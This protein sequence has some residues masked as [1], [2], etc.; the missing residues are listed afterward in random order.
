[1]A[2]S[3]HTRLQTV[4]PYDAWVDAM[5]TLSDYS[6]NLVKSEDTPIFAEL[7]RLQ[8]DS[9]K[10]HG[11]NSVNVVDLR[12]GTGRCVR[13]L[14]EGLDEAQVERNESPRGW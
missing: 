3:M 10:Q 5:F 6:A 14:W 13:K 2:A 1:M 7:V 11:R 9:A 4:L 12:T 8:I